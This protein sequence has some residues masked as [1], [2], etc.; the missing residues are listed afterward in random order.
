M[1][2][3]PLALALAAAAF[4][5]SWRWLAQRTWWNPE[6]AVILLVTAVL[7]L[8]LAARRILAE[9]TL[10]PLPALPLAAAIIAHMALVRVAPPLAAASLAVTTTLAA[11]WIA[12]HGARP[13][14]AFWGLCL[15]IMPVLPTLQFFLGYPMRLVAAALTVPLLQLNGLAVTRSGVT[16]EW[17]GET[18]LFDAPCS[19]VTMLWAGLLLLF[20]ITTIERTTWLELARATFLA[21]RL[22]LAANVLR[23]ASLFYLE[24]GA[25]ALPLD[26]A[27]VHESVGLAAYGAAL[28]VLVIALQRMRRPTPC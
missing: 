15:L 16:L 3:A 9:R 11:V 6:D 22:L 18:I 4:W 2:S 24:T 19:G 1:M 27:Q 7:V 10:S 14:P 26:G 5:E 13:P 17:R 25:L 20:V 12:T 23:A 8:G 21:L 28:L